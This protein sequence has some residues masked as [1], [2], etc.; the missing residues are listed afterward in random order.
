[1]VSFQNILG[2]QTWSFAVGDKSD[3]D[4]TS[5]SAL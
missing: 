5:A 1:M 3:V 4:A 2:A